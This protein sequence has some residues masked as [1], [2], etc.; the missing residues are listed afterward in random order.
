[1]QAII[2]YTIDGQ[3]TIVAENEIEAEEKFR[4]LSKEEL[5]NGLYLEEPHIDSIA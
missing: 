2:N 1:M 4:E 3:I 5:I